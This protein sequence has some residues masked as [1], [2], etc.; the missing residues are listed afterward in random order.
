MN[1]HGQIPRNRGGVC[2]ALLILLG[3]WGGL[4]PFVGPYFH[5]GYTPDKAWAYDSGRLYYSVIPGAAAL[6]GG[7]LVTMTRNRG[8]GIG[9]GVIAALAG[10]WFVA[11]PGIDFEVLNRYVSFGRP[12]ITGT[13][14]PLRSYL[15]SISLFT[16][17]SILILAVGGIA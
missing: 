4:A 3:L 7:V 2:G 16:G 8:V 5:Y 13:S 15:E 12:I 17:L 6:L 11:G 10:A 1:R 14:G 9:G